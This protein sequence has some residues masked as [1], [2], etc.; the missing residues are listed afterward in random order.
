[1]RLQSGR[2][3]ARP[4]QGH[5]PLCHYYSKKHVTETDFSLSLGCIRDTA[6]TVASTNRYQRTGIRT[7]R[8]P[9]SHVSY[10]R[11]GAPAK[12]MSNTSILSL[13]SPSSRCYLHPFLSSQSANG[14]LVL[15]RPLFIICV[16][17]ASVQRLHTSRT[18][19][20]NFFMFTGAHWIPSSADF[21]AGATTFLGLVLSTVFFDLD[22]PV[23]PGAAP[24]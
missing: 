20:R 7:A 16:T 13:V 3:P 1:M 6:T 4:V 9:D 18:I 21:P 5:F 24:L 8:D 19:R 12:L 17:S 23:S 10:L 15:S 22:F 11:I 2:K 14:L